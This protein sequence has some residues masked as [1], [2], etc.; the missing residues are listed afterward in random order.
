MDGA[1]IHTAQI[2]AGLAGSFATGVPS[3]ALAIPAA[4]YP[5]GVTTPDQA[6]TFFLKWLVGVNPTTD[7]QHRCKNPP[8]NCGLFGDIYHSTPQVVG[9][10]SSLLRD[11]SYVRFA[12]AN[13]KRPIVLYTSTNDG[14][15]HA[16]KVTSND[17]ADSGTGSTA[18][19]NRVEA[20]GNN[21]LWAFAPPAV[22]PNIYGLYPYNHLN[23]LDG[24][25]AVRDVVAIEQATPTN[26][27]VA[28]ERTAGD[29]RSGG[30]T[31]RTI[32]VQGFGSD[33]GGYFALDVTKPVADDA[34]LSDTSK[35]GPR[36]LWQLTREAMTSPLVAGKD[37]FGRGGGTPAIAT[38]FFDPAGGSNAREIPVA[39]LPGGPGGTVRASAT[40][41]P[42]SPASP[43]TFPGVSI[44]SRFVPRG[45]VKC[46]DHPGGA[47]IGA[48]SLTIV[49]LDT[50][51]IIRTFRQKLTDVT[52]PTLQ[53]RVTLADL[54][55]PIIGQPVAFPGQVG[56]V[57]DRIIVGDQDGRLW[58]VNVSA[59]NPA[60]WTMKLFFD[61]FPATVQAAAAHDFSDGQPITTTPVLSIDDRGRMTVNAATGDQDSLAYAPGQTNYV[62]SFT[63]DFDATHTSVI[64]KVNWSKAFLNG[65]RVIG[66]LALFNTDLFF[67][68]YYGATGTAVCTLGQSELWGMD[69]LKPFSTTDFKQ[70]G[71][72]VFATQSVDQGNVVLSGVSVAQQ[73]SCYVSNADV[74]VDDLVG[75]RGVSRISQ[76]NPGKFELIMHEN[77][78]SGTATP[79]EIKTRTVELPTPPSLSRIASWAS[80]VE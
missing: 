35:G 63:E 2:Q 1:G 17:P 39:I 45:R 52:N 34:S 62:Y 20:P 8:N 46:Y 26:P 51:E 64:N 24:V 50:G 40:G 4:A 25:A 49:R 67:A 41:C 7:K 71:E 27:P 48:H 61:L 32:L 66:P 37:L 65:K 57:A 19:A 80:I 38:L 22:L 60:A 44:D 54:D 33:H 30:G 12:G 75:Y 9:A 23:L 15:L 11:E 47:E 55:S 69:Y 59:K 16:F 70:G 5:T 29:A 68:T 13:A 31:W 58:K 53:S 28:F 36:F 72:A 78:P 73:P 79:D 6:R 42:E 77:Q 14:F 76:I 74:L 21:E 43:R 10:P 18:L 3:E 56:A